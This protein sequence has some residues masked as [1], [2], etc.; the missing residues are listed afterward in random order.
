MQFNK[1]HR[2]ERNKTEDARTIWG[3]GERSFTGERP[4]RRKRNCSRGCNRSPKGGSQT[5]I[6]REFSKLDGETIQWRF[7]V[8]RVTQSEVLFSEAPTSTAFSGNRLYIYFG[9]S[10][11]GYL[12]IG[13]NMPMPF[14]EKLRPGDQ[15]LIKGRAQVRVGTR[16]GPF[17]NSW[18]NEELVVAIQLSELEVRA[19]DMEQEQ[20]RQTAEEQVAELT[21]RRTASR[22]PY[23]SAFGDSCPKALYWLQHVLRPHVA[24][25]FNTSL[26]V[27]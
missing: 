20:Q 17:S 24:Q 5:K 8:N 14:A 10:Q 1:H 7:T 3:N 21:R 18:V 11:P 27:T 6:E 2:S 16:V 25:A 23:L 19:A 9:D 4:E 26:R 13:K 15:L 22:M 12:P